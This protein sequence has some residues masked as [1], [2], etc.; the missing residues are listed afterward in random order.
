MLRNAFLACLSPAFIACGG[1]HH[2][3]DANGTGSGSD[4]ATD[5]NGSGNGSGPGNPNKCLE[6][7][8][9]CTANTDCC[10]VSCVNNV[11]SGTQCTADNQACT[12]DGQCCGGKCGTGGTCT[13][14]NAAARPTATRARRAPSA[15][16]RCAT[17]RSLRTVVVLYAGRRRVRARR[18]VL[19]RQ[20][21]IGGG[22][23]IGLCTH[24]MPG[25]TNC[26]AGVDGTVCSGCGDCCSRLCEVYAPTGAKICQPAEGCRVDGDICH[27]DSDCCGA[28]APVCPAT[29]NVSASRSTAQIPRV[30]AATRSRAIPKAT[31]ATTRTTRRAATRRRVTTAAAVPATRASVKL[32]GLGVP[33][34]YGLGSACVQVGDSCA[35]NGD[36]CNGEPCVPDQNGQL[37]CGARLRE[38]ERHCA[39]RPRTAVTARPACSP[40]ARRSAP[41]AAARAAAAA[42]AAAPAR[43]TVR[44]AARTATA[45]TWTAT[46]STRA[47][48]SSRA[49][50]AGRLHLLHAA[51]LS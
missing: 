50:R 48:R 38:H 4:A 7:G 37:H 34:C 41:A 24:P 15:A 17:R 13:P 40:R 5:G 27:Q 49:R 12:S 29:G 1:G 26:Q 10:T 31:S 46:S 32:D 19:R 39:P 3:T 35:F 6:A 8:S 43:S 42:A 11:C 20:C 51:V 45:A 21:T 9:G 23:A 47:A 18:R 2:S 14:L 44:C 30:S 33:R 36:C 22:Q 16:P 25:S 28:R